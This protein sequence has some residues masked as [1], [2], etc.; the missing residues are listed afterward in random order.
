MDYH[1]NAQGKTFGRLMTEIATT[2]QGKR[3]PSYHPAKAGD[4][5]VLLSN[6]AAMSLTGRKMT[7]KVYHRHTGYMGHLKTLSFE[8]AFEKNP[9]QVIRDAVRRMMPKNFL[10]QKRL[11]NLIF[12]DDAS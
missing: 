3:S 9:K 2:L 7:E 12:V 11:N 4:D 10:N 6:Y 8:Q 5:R 1:I